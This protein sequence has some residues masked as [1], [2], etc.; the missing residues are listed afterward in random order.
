[1]R[2]TGTLSARNDLSRHLV[3][4]PFPFR[5]FDLIPALPIASRTRCADSITLAMSWLPV[6][7]LF[8]VMAEHAA[9][10]IP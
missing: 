10:G 9:P 6:W 5:L 4:S 3:Y 1:M 7:V 8:D 2:A